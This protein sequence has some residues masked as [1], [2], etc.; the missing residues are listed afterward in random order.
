VGRHS[1]RS[2][3]VML[4]HAHPQVR[5]APSGSE[6]PRAP[7]ARDAAASSAALHSQKQLAPRTT[8]STSSGAPPESLRLA[9]R[10]GDRRCASNLFDVLGRGRFGRVLQG[11]QKRPAPFWPAD[12]IHHQAARLSAATILYVPR[13]RRAPSINAFCVCTSAMTYCLR[14][15]G[16]L[17]L[18]LRRLLRVPDPRAFFRA[19]AFH[20]V[21]L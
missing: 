16:V 17:P 14:R 7:S 18:V 10:I 2:R 21:A 13:Q 19:P 15:C 4:G 1:F 6:T 11:V 20:A 9:L 3:H 12:Q 5:G 8:W